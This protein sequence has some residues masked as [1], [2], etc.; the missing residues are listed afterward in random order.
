MVIVLICHISNR[1]Y[2]F[3]LF[4]SHIKYQK[5]LAGQ[6][7]INM[8]NFANFYL[9]HTYTCYI[10][11]YFRDSCYRVGTLASFNFLKEINVPIKGKRDDASRE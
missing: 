4:E 7:C 6:N 3:V 1:Y 5:L 8:C 10:P 11:T 2:R 9:L